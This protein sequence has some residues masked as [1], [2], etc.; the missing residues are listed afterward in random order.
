MQAE[1]GALTGWSGDPEYFQFVESDAHDINLVDDVL[2]GRRVGAVLREYADLDSTSSMLAAFAASPALARRESE[3][4]SEY[5]GAYHY[6]KNPG[7]YLD[8]CEAVDEALADIIDRPDSPWRRFHE[9]LSAEL[10]QRGVGLRRASHWG[11]ESAAGIVRSWA[12]QGPY[13][14]VPHEDSSQCTEPRQRDFEI[15]AVGDRVCAVNLCLAN[16]RDGRLAVWNVIPN[17]ASRIRLGT[18]KTGAPYSDADL[19]AF[20]F[21]WVSVRPGD[22]YVLRSAHVHAVERN[23]D[24][25][26]TV[27]ALLGPVDDETVVVWT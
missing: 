24:Y 22:L 14:L 20:E 7:R 16:G 18:D 2:A 26:A 27:A 8:E 1:S 10:A 13:S 23:S 3:A 12:G 11:R 5:V 19:A 25:R 15:G 17:Q 4:E 9:E 21:R 6:H